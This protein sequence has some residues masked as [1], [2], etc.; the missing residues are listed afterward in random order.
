L[1][2]ARRTERHQ[3]VEIE[4]RAPLGALDDAVDLECPRS[5]MG[6]SIPFSLRRRGGQAGSWISSAPH[7]GPAGRLADPGRELLANLTEIKFDLGHAIASTAPACA[8]SSMRSILTR[9]TRN[10]AT[11]AV[12]RRV[13]GHNALH[14]ASRVE[15][16]SAEED[17]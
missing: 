8:L 1:G 16:R 12:P 14:R 3:P 10:Q 17:A 4:V 2:M 13:G 5:G 9:G 7:G 11:T 6:A 15:V